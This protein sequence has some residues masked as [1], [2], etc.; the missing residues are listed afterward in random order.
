MCPFLKRPKRPPNSA[1]GGIKD[2]GGVGENKG[3]QGEFR[4]GHN[5]SATVK[6]DLVQYEIT[7]EATFK[8][9][10]TTYF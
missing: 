7:F 2:Y 4:P 9:S 5:A 10:I 1:T 3:S 8:R 6:T